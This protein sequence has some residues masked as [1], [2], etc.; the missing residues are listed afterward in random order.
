MILST[1]IGEDVFL[2]ESIISDVFPNIEMPIPEYQELRACVLADAKEHNLQTPTL[3]LDKL[4]QLYETINTRHGNMVVGPTCSGK[5]TIWK[6]LA[7]S[8]TTLKKNGVRGFEA[9]EIEFLNP[10]SISTDELFGS[11]GS[12]NEW[13]DG[14]LSNI[15]RR[16]CN[17]EKEHWKWFMLDGPVDTLWIESMNTVLD[18]NKV[19]T[20]VNG[21][22][23]SLSGTTRMLFEVLDLDVASPATVSRCGMLYMDSFVVGWENYVKSWL[24][25]KTLP[26]KDMQFT[27]EP[28]AAGE[29]AVPLTGTPAVWPRASC[30]MLQLLFNK[31][32]PTL[33]KAR[34]AHSDSQIVAIS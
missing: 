9:V 14:I 12:T 32:V 22:R 13:S 25:A 18:D 10:K 19:L 16:L 31:Y 28:Q 2:F 5:S 3:F 4:F 8:M 11:Y 27:S 33:L 29:D 21:D 17:D 30:D 7:R 24:H 1:L 6:T 26:P 20:L 34:N 15:L 23:I